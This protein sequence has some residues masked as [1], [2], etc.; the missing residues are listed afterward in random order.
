[1]N[2]DRD[3][4]P[5]V[6]LSCNDTPSLM[7]D[8]IH[9][10]AADYLL[11][12]LRL[13]T[14]K[15]L[16]LK[17]HA[18]SSASVFSA[19]SS[20]SSAS[21]ASSA[22]SLPMCLNESSFP[23]SPISCPDNFL[24][25]TS[26]TSTLNN[27][28]LSDRIK[29]IAH[30][31]L[32]LSKAILDIYMP[33]SLSAVTYT[34]LSSE[35]ATTLKAAIV[36]WDFCPFD[37]SP[38]DLIH[39]VYLIFQH[40][41]P[42]LELSCSIAQ[43]QLYAF[44]MD[45]SSVYHEGNPYHNF[46]H[47]VDVL[48]CLYFLLCQTPWKPLSPLHSLLR[49]KDIFALFIAAIGH[50]AAHPG[51]NNMFLINASTPLALLYNDRS[52][53]ESLHSMALFQLIKKHGLEECLGGSNSPDYQEFRKTVI[54]SI[55]ATDM[56]LHNDY[57]TKIKEQAVRLPKLET[58]VLEED[59]MPERLL[60]CSALIK[61]ADISNVT[62]PFQQA[63]QWA[64]LLVEEFVCQGDL[65]RQ[66]GMPVLPMHDRA[67]VV[68]EDSQI[69][70]IRFV[71]LDL[72]RSVKTVVPEMDFAVQHMERNLVQWEYRQHIPVVRDYEKLPLTAQESQQEEQREVRLSLD[73]TH[74]SHGVFYALPTM[75]TRA[76]ESYGDRH[77]SIDLNTPEDR[78]SD[79]PSSH[80]SSNTITKNTTTTTTT[81]TNS[82]LFTMERS[83]YCQCTIQ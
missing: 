75:P 17:L 82:A 43:T 40:I 36:R 11:K 5:M 23:S 31:D 55:L 27:D 51:V 56:S 8:C 59:P 69:G 3:R 76:M 47:A 25:S 63:E 61:C 2:R 28:T 12:P 30:R 50:D 4:V 38:S 21:S 32:Q 54:T 26:I 22:S 14:V 57:V 13:E 49:P 62:R 66:L 45:L 39:C 81:I 19:L 68:L 80:F 64:E 9:A 37:Y 16:F 20:S 71:A 78:L 35:H 42:S 53:L 60:L 74:N 65:E 73:S 48:Q 46:A 77:V 29:E 52:V 15:T 10:G 70:F 1:M 7:L 44:I 34:P 58:R 24:S 67:K 33:T 79:W 72:F 83:S 41:L 6:V 18:R